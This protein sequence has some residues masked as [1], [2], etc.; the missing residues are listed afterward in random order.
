MFKATNLGQTILVKKQHQKI[1]GILNRQGRYNIKKLSEKPQT[2]TNIEQIDKKNEVKESDKNKVALN[3]KIDSSKEH[4][5]NMLGRQH[6][7]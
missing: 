1:T 6:L 2:N 4:K 3:P 7:I 5:Y